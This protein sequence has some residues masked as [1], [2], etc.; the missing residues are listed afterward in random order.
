M[1]RKL[2]TEHKAHVPMHCKLKP[3]DRVV[4]PDGRTGVVFWVVELQGQATVSVQ[5]DD[6]WGWPLLD[7]APENLKL[8]EKTYLQLSLLD[9]EAA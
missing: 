9:L 1:R 2:P 8:A 6:T 4:T 5:M 3:G 7:Y